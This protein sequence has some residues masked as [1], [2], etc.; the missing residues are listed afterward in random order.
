M[1]CGPHRSVAF[2]VLR[3]L[4]SRHLARILAPFFRASSTPERHSARARYQAGRH[5][6]P[7]R[8]C[9]RMHLFGLCFQEDGRFGVSW[10][11]E[12]DRRYGRCCGEEVIDGGLPSSSVG[13]WCSASG[14]MLTFRLLFRNNVALGAD[15]GPEAMAVCIQKLD[16]GRGDSDC[17]QTRMSRIRRSVSSSISR[18]SC[19]FAVSADV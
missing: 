19:C 4:R 9:V 12:F 15:N 1:F 5:R 17:Y 7:S 3:K 13:C 2:T 8:R 16:R 11:S 18:T 14:C 6:A 10:F